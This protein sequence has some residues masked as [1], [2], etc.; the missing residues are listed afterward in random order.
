MTAMKPS[1]LQN[2]LAVIKKRWPE[3]YCRLEDADPNSLHV[4][5]LENTLLINGIQ[6]CSNYNRAAEASL[7]ADSVSTLKKTVAVYGPAAGDLPRALLQKGK[8]SQLQIILLNRAVFLYSLAF[9]D[10][11]DWLAHPAVSLLFPLDMISLHTPFC[12][13]PAELI[14]AEEA[15][16]PLRDRIEQ[17][18]NLEY[19]NR[20]HLTSDAVSQKQMKECLPFLEKDSSISKLS[21]PESPEIFVAAAGPTLEMHFEYLKR[22]NVYLIAVDATLRALL[23][24]GIIPDVV[25]SIDAIAST[26]FS[27][28][29]LSPLARTPLVYLP[30]ADTKLLKQ[31]PGPRFFSCGKTAMFATVPDQF[32]MT[33]LFSAGSVIHP[34]VDLAV[35]LGAETIILL[36]ADFSF[37]RGKSHAN[38]TPSQES[39]LPPELA[40]YLVLNGQGKQVATMASFKSYLRDLEVFIYNHQEITFLNGSCEGARIAGTKPWKNR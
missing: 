8:A 17:E 1:L 11:R 15:T 31:W 33:F 12:C 21:R 30:G 19:S 14:L 25:V 13:S 10:Q 9:Y 23:P 7:Q 20:Q 40:R 38:A 27:G 2:N 37:T 34:A 39:L 22:E 5:E 4:I 35:Y 6:L 36:G 26:L 3:L 29:N 16:A 24:L 28:L 32:K 18:L